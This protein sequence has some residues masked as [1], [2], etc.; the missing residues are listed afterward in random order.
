MRTPRC[1]TVVFQV[2]AALLGGGRAE[3]PAVRLGPALAGGA[4][5]EAAGVPR[6]VADGCR[7]GRQ[8]ERFP[9]C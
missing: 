8:R 5:A 4:A 6:A 9:R 1:W 2:L 7:R 3:L